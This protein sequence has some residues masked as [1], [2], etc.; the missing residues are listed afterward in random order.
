M[1][2]RPGKNPPLFDPTESSS[3]ATSQRT[4]YAGR[5]SSWMAGATEKFLQYI[6]IK[7]HARVQKNGET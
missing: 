4:C 7:M 1:T 3:P 6:H 2:L 5:L